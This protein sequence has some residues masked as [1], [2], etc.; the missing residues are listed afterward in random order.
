[1]M[2]IPG[3]MDTLPGVYGPTGSELVRTP[4]GYAI[5][6]Y[7]IEMWN[8]PHIEGSIKDLAREAFLARGK[9]PA[10]EMPQYFGQ[11]LGQVDIFGALLISFHPETI[12]AFKE[13]L[14]VDDSINPEE[15]LQEM[16]RELNRLKPL[17][18]FL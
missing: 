10:H 1:M 14:R 8:G 7:P 9:F 6:W 5:G 13:S 2:F 17:I 3:I 4:K 15:F 18:L 16:N 11:G 12:C